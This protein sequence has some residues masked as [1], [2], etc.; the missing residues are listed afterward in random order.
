MYAGRIVERGP[1]A[2][3]FADPQH[4]YTEALLQSIPLLGMRTRRR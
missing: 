4:P 1:V 3:V 2:D